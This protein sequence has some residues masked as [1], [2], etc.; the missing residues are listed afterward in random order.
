MRL[1]RQ[2]RKF[3]FTFCQIL[4]DRLSVGQVES[5]SAINLF[6][7][8]RRKS[9][10]YGLWRFALQELV[11]HGVERHS[12]RNE[13]VAAVALLDICA[14]RSNRIIADRKEAGFAGQLPN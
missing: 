1:F 6:Q 2:L 8:K 4:I 3:R 11:H 10:R 7:R 5:E 9:L 14:H 13:I 12:T